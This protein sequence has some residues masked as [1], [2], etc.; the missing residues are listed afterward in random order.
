MFFF[1]KSIN[2]FQK[3]E[4]TNYAKLLDIYKYRVLMFDCFSW[5]FCGHDLMY[6]NI[7]WNKPFE[8]LN[9]LIYT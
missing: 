9:C 5:I 3:I 6:F 4:R 8:A 7:N 1:H 2:L